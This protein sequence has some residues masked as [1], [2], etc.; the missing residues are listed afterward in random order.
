MSYPPHFSRA[1]LIFSDYAARNDINNNPPPDVEPNLL[2]LANWLEVLRG[3][4]GAPIT[5]SSGYRSVYLNRAIGGSPN[6]AHVYGLAADI[7]TSIMTP[8]EFAIEIASY[9]FEEGYD[10][11]ILEYDR[12]VH[13]GLSGKTQRLQTLTAT[14]EHGATI[15]SEGIA[16]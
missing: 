7:R 15:Y 4:I 3:H 13:V 6:S 10:Q 5:V 14:R 9:M 8:R 11:I 2:R 1:E 12:W 16:L